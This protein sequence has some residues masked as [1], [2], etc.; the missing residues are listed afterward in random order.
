MT[1]KALYGVGERT[2]EMHHFNNSSVCWIVHYNDEQVG[3]SRCMLLEELRNFFRQH[4]STL[5][6]QTGSKR[7]SVPLA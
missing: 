3:I 5:C 1:G 2:K 6:Y 7:S 4:L